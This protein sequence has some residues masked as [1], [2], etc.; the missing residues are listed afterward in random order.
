MQQNQTQKTPPKTRHAVIGA[1]LGQPIY[2]EFPSEDEAIKRL[3]EL[4]YCANEIYDAGGKFN[5]R[6]D[7]LDKKLRFLPNGTSILDR[8][9]NQIAVEI[10]QKP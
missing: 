1:L 6:P 7:R 4:A 8:Y 3:D 2:E 5:L 10:D 9:F